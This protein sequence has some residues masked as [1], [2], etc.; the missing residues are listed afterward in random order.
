MIFIRHV[1]IM[2]YEKKNKGKKKKTEYNIFFL[3]Y[4]GLKPIVQYEIH[5][6]HRSYL[7]SCP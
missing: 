4:L 7:E 6:I 1:D 3:V 2:Q 5:P